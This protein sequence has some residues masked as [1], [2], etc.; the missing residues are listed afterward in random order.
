MAHT[1]TVSALSGELVASLTGLSTSKDAAAFKRVR[2]GAVRAF[3]TQQYARTNQFEV[4]KTLDGVVEKFQILYREDLAEALD[5]RLKKLQPL[6]TKW[7]PEIL[8]LL[9][10][11]SDRPLE[12]TTLSD[13]DRLRPPVPPPQLTWQDILR[14]DPLTE[15]G[16]W[17]DIDYAAHGSSDEDS[18][19]V[20]E[21][22]EAAKDTPA[23]SIAE[24]DLVASVQ[25]FSI[26]PDATHIEKIRRAQKPFKSLSS[27]SEDFGGELLSIGITELMVVRETLFMLRG[28]PTTVFDLE[29][30]TGIVRFK[31]SVALPQS[32]S[33]STAVLLKELAGLGSRV[34]ALRVWSRE[35]HSVALLQSFQDAICRRIWAFDRSVST[36]ERKFMDE[37][38]C[39]VVSIIEICTDAEILARPLL[40]L[41]G[42]TEDLSTRLYPLQCLELLF[43][44][45]C[46]AQL[47]EDPATFEELG[48][49]FFTCLQVY[50]RPIRGWM[51]D[52]HIDKDDRVF[53]VQENQKISDLSSLWHNRFSLRLDSSGELHAPHFLRA[54]FKRIFN[55]G[56]TIVFRKSLEIDQDQ[57]TT[58]LLEPSL[59]YHSVCKSSSDGDLLPFAET[60]AT[61]FNEWVDSKHT[62][63]SVTVK[64]QL[65][66]DCGLSRSL[67][68]LEFLF[69][70][71]NGALFQAFADTLFEKL[72]NRSRS[73][74]D[75]FLAN[76]LMEAIYSGV[77]PVDTENISIRTLPN[78]ARIRSVRRLGTIL[79]D[80]PLPWPIAN[81]IRKH[82]MPTYQKVF[83]LLLQVYRAAY[84]LRRL[85]FV[86]LA[87]NHR[88]R[89]THLLRFRMSRFVDTLQD[90]LT[91]TVIGISTA[92]MRKEL[93]EADDVDTMAS[94]HQAYVQKLEA[95][96]LLAKNFSPFHKAIIQILDLVV[97]FSD[98]HTS[99]HKSNSSQGENSFTARQK[100]RRRRSALQAAALHEESDS[101]PDLDAE[102]GA[103][104]GG[105]E[106]DA[107]T[108]HVGILEGSFPERVRKASKEFDK[109]NH[110]IIAGLRQI[111]RT[112]SE[113]CW[114][115]LAERL[116]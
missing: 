110:F 81:I 101:E 16:V 36:I 27:H 79:I 59:D 34:N 114:E 38:G 116:E 47:T 111:G 10:E 48:I 28:L 8:S 53:F 37:K 62:V 11:L 45:V 73:W 22:Q 96:C 14:E 60:F 61:A 113:A 66:K 44:R 85:A 4:H 20:D 78:K 7:T 33:A 46:L 64:Q 13:L 104:E 108:E 98:T 76:D 49:I 40:Q 43:D 99:L 91:E 39:A 3:R 105:D 72:D 57:D 71:R 54:S 50:L 80:Y 77:S 18:F 93:A 21:E 65:F 103:S 41:Q 70:S 56:K 102:D 31:E 115:M 35:Q 5:L 107:D 82:S 26:V 52:G 83:A 9:L 63:A 24:D 92:Q 68:A 94:A 67:D 58:M 89:T 29:S 30:E 32:S 112:G 23:T 86:S 90:Y 88:I 51:E 1:S 2:E 106:Y 95:Q 15:E 87:A 75:R 42:L 55:T 109:L 69:L 25:Q 84:L 17:D 12:K 74:D 19:Y 97:A 6:S 100:Q